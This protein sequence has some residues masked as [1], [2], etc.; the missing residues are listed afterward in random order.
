MKIKAVVFDFGGVIELY[1]GGR[2]SRKF[3]EVLEVDYDKFKAVYFEHN[4]LSN[5]GN[6][7][8]EEM[9]LKVAS[10][11]DKSKEKEAQIKAIIQENHSKLKINSEL[12]TFFKILRQQGLKVAIFS[13][14][15][16]KLRKRLVKED[17]AGLVDEIVISGEIGHQK[18]NKEAFQILFEKLGCRPEEV[19]F[20]DDTKKSLEKASE[21]GYIPILFKNNELLKVDLYSHGILLTQQNTGADGFTG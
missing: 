17:I 12:L 7:K 16:S 13:N 18:P 1:E 2:I 3:A 19:I 8:W 21:I 20:I 9:V 4:H 6:L 14:A 5:V 15:T 11:F 10:V